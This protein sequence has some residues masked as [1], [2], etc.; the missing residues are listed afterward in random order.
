M[1]DRSPWLQMR[2]YPARLTKCPEEPDITLSAS[3]R[4]HWKITPR[5]EPRTVYC[6][7]VRIHSLEPKQKKKSACQYVCV[8]AYV[9]VDVI[10]VRASL[11]SLSTARMYTRCSQLSFLFA[12]AQK[13]SDSVCMLV[14]T[15]RRGKNQPYRSHP[16]LLFR[17]YIRETSS[18][19]R[20]LAA[21][22]C[23]P[24]MTDRHSSSTPFCRPSPAW[25]SHLAS[26]FVVPSYTTDIRP[27]SVH[28]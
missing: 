12:Q 22:G 10:S 2:P 26:C 27:S 14:K 25:C 28:R 3:L 24:C 1:L 11:A 13:M 20:A 23:L 15:K 17:G 16:K 5:G 9:R 6:T 7:Y 19:S 18:T 21:P 4:N 8:D